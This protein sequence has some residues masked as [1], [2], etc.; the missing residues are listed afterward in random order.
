[1]H[2]SV[3]NVILNEPYSLIS[4]QKCSSIEAFLLALY[5]L[6]GNRYVVDQVQGSKKLIFIVIVIKINNVGGH[7]FNF[8]FFNKMLIKMMYPSNF[9]KFLTFSMHSNQSS[10]MAT[11][12][13]QIKLTIIDK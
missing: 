1:M 6:V 13:G 5:N 8:N 11:N 3:L 2:L 9:Q 10:K 12:D 4:F 7:L